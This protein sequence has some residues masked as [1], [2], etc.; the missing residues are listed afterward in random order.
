MSSCSAARPSLSEHDAPSFDLG[1]SPPT[2]QPTLLTSQPTVTQLEV[3]EKAVV[4]AGVAAALKFT[5]AT[6]AEPSFTA[7]ETTHVKETKDSTNEYDPIFILKHKANFEGLRHQFLSLMPEQHVKS[8]VVNAHCV[9]LNDIKC[10]RFQ[11]DIYCVPIDIVMFM[12]GTHGE[13]YID[14]KITKAY[15]MDWLWIANV[16]KKAFYVLDPVNKKKDEI[17]DLRIKLNKFVGLI[18]SQMRVYAGAE[19]L[20]EV[21]EGEEAEYIRLNGQHTRYDYAIYVK[22]WLETI[23]LRKIKKGKRFDPSLFFGQPLVLTRGRF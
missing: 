4:D 19:P 20:M 3:L 16:Q 10:S 7:V 6:S 18:I 9:I 15:R 8:T 2:S 22:K 12:L 1:I 23:D 11:E 21:G 13:N 17:T 5:D 14:P